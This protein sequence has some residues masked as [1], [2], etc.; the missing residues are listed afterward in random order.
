MSP[1]W[2]E[3]PKVPIETKIYTVV[4]LVDVIMYAEFQD[5][6]YRSTILQGVEFPIFLFFF[7]MGDTSL[8][9]IKLLIKPVHEMLALK[10]SSS[11]CRPDHVISHTHTISHMGFGSE[12]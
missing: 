8:P 3:A 10:A 2:T 9:V 11:A 7:C 1:I 5:Y 4:N 6:T 12:Y